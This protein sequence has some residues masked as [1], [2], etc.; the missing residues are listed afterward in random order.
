MRSYLYRFGAP[1]SALALFVGMSELY[2]YGDKELYEHILRAY[3]VLPFRLPFVD[4]SAL[5]AA[6]ECTRLG[7]DVI[8][9]S[10]CDVL[11]R[12][13]EYSPL[14]MAVSAIPLDAGDT[15]AVG[16]GLDL[17][18]LLSLAL[19][20]PPQ[21]LPEFFLVLAATLSTTVVFAVERANADL[22][23]FLLALATGL[24]T[25]YRLFIRLFGYCL[26]LA[27]AL[28][29]YYPLLILVVSLRERPPVFRLIATVVLGSLTL[30]FV[31]YHVEIARG[32]AQ[33]PRGSYNTEFFSAQ[34]LPF[35]LGEVIGQSA[36][37]SI[38]G[39]I[40]AGGV[41]AVL[42][43]SCVA[44]L[45]RLL[46]WIEL[47]AALALL[48]HPERTLLVIG[49]A[50]IAGCFF[51]G[52]NIAYRGVFLLLVLPGLLAIS[53][54]SARGLRA[55]GL[56][57]S[58]M[59]VLLMW[60]ECFRLALW[61]SAAIVPFWLLRELCWWGLVGVLLGVLADLLASVP[62]GQSMSALLVRRAAP[63]E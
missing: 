34:N 23:M 40:A 52:P 27:G 63:Q 20:P 9:V 49:S 12:P 53:R 61:S 60:G 25:Q 37:S 13:F 19:L 28:L 5:L 44:L 35:L 50:V 62:I 54:G 3:G 2:R 33:I 8:T 24:L 7:L 22:L 48:P 46:R 36:S 42:T 43:G 4:T 51:A 39:R 56:G 15:I 55:L 31:E 59:I 32:L 41:F 29:K 1:G 47:Y 58:F 17:V 57:I 30:F 21:R 11:H 14:W 18:F 16:W 6:W 45:C 38:I 10:P 26:G